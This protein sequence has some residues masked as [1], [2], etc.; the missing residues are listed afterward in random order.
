MWNFGALIVV[1]AR[2]LTLYSKGKVL[3]GKLSEVV[4]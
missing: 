3:L 2:E 1:C 4:V